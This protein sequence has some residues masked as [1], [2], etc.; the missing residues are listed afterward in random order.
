MPNLSDW[1]PGDVLLFGGK[2]TG[3]PVAAQIESAQR[4]WFQRKQVHARWV[5]VAVYLGRGTIAESVMTSFPAGITG[6]VVVDGED[7]GKRIQSGQ[8]IRLRR[9]D[10]KLPSVGSV[11]DAGYRLATHTAS[12]AGTPYNYNVLLKMLAARIS[13]LL[14][15]QGLNQQTIASLF[16][17]NTLSPVLCSQLVDF[18]LRDAGLPAI[19]NSSTVPPLPYVFSESTLFVDVPL[20]WRRT[21]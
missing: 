20:I 16:N 4:Q 2:P 21:L 18:A 6:G 3:D 8:P 17:W 12:F 9:L 1:E 15:R 19:S 5:H 13:S 11:P 10:K 7:L 14:L